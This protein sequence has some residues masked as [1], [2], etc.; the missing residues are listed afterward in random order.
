MELLLRGG[1]SMTATRPTCANPSAYA[2]GPPWRTQRDEL[3]GRL[4]CGI[5]KFKKFSGLEMEISKKLFTSKM[6]GNGLALARTASSWYSS[7]A[8]VKVVRRG[9]GRC[10]PVFLC[11]RL[12]LDSAR[13]AGAGRAIRISRRD[14]WPEAENLF[15]QH[16]RDAGEGRKHFASAR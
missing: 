4:Y 11:W 9:Y 5:G 8:P 15:G 6:G 3:R 13:R 1:I 12:H 16:M 2:A 14:L 7:S 10:A